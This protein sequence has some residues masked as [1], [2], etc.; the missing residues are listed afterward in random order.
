MNKSLRA[1]GLLLAILGGIYGLYSRMTHHVNK[2]ASVFTQ[3]RLPPVTRDDWGI[4]VGAPIA[5]LSEHAINDYSPET[6]EDRELGPNWGIH[7]REDL[8]HQLFWLV[9]RGTS[10]PFYGIRDEVTGMNKN[11]FDKLLA[12]IEQSQVDE[13]TKKEIIWQYN[14]MYHNTQ[15]IQNIK[16]QALDYVRFSMLCLEGARLKY[17]TENEAKTWTLMLVPHLR[18]VFQGWDELWHHYLMTRWLWTAQEKYLS[19]QPELSKHIDNLLKDKDSPAKAI[20]WYT[21]LSLVDT[22]S[23]AEAVASLNW[24]NEQGEIAGVDELNEIIKSYLDITDKQ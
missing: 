14:T 9:R 2:E 11:E 20:E 1:G 23:F 3:S 24:K 5:M 10:R 15:N 18:E 7:S 8:I 16:Y 4:I 6:A 13:N 12:K 19:A 22:R 17:I 21:P